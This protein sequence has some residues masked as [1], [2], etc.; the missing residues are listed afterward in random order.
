MAGNPNRHSAGPV[1]LAL[2]DEWRTRMPWRDRALGTLLTLPLLGRYG[3]RVGG[4][5]FKG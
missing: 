1:R 2:D 4:T 5:S 3:Y